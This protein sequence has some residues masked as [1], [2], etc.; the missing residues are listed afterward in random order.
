MLRKYW[1]VRCGAVIVSARWRIVLDQ[2]S[3]AAWPGSHGMRGSCGIRPLRPHAALLHKAAFC[4]VLAS[5]CAK[6]PLGVAHR[7]APSRVSKTGLMQSGLRWR[8][9][10]SAVGAPRS[11][12]RPTPRRLCALGVVVA[13]GH[14]SGAAR[15]VLVSGL[16]PVMWCVPPPTHRGLAAARHWPARA[17]C[18]PPPGDSP[19]RA[20]A[21]AS[22]A[23]PHLTHQ[24]PRQR[25]D[26]RLH[27]H[28]RRCQPSDDLSL[29]RTLDLAVA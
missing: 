29:A 24:R 22:N 1:S 25:A 3:P 13:P 4:K 23:T 5:R 10:A 12:S 15:F 2:P 19:N 20:E 17:G 8:A 28:L 14:W 21:V 18:P 16:R 7:C 9:G 27:R 6:A 11:H 26:I